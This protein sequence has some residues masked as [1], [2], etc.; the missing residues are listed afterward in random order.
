MSKSIFPL[1]DIQ[2][3]ISGPSDLEDLKNWIPEQFNLLLFGLFSVVIFAVMPW[4][5]ALPS[6]LPHPVP[7]RRAAPLAKSSPMEALGKKLAN[8]GKFSIYCYPWC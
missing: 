5:A 2:R 4:R 3:D 6:I 8:R 7:V 1:R